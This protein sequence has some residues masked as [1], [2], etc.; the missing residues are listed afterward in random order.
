MTLL[1][2]AGMVQP[3][4]DEQKKL[5]ALAANARAA[6]ALRKKK[7]EPVEQRLSPRG[8]A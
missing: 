6:Q 1:I 7:K 8:S 4:G 2:S 3:G 5:G